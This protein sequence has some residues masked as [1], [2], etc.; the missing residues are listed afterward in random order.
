MPHSERKFFLLEQNPGWREAWSQ[1]LI[2]AEDGKELRLRAIPGTGRPLASPDGDFGGLSLPSGVAVDGDDRVYILEAKAGR[3]KRFDPC[4]QTFTSLPCIAGPGDQ[5]RQVC[6]P[7]SLAVSPRGDLYIA[8]TGNRR[9]QV[10]ALKGL[11]L[12]AIWGPIL[13]TGIGTSAMRIDPTAARASRALAPVQFAAVFPPLNAVAGPPP[14][15]A[16]EPADCAPGRVFPRCTWEPWDIA[17]DPGCWAFV[18]DRVN[19]L[20][21]RFDP[22]GRWHSA[23]AEESPGVRLSKPTSLALDRSGRLYVIQEGKDY[24]VVLDETGGFVER[25]QAPEEAEGRFDPQA[26]TVDSDGNLCVS[27]RYTRALYRYCLDAAGCMVYAGLCPVDGPVAA[28]A[29]DK[30]GNLLA[31]DPQ[32]GRVVCLP[33][34]AALETD[35]VFY[36]EALDSQIYRCAW[37]QVALQASVPPGSLIRVDTFTSESLKT[38]DEIRSLEQESRWATGQFYTQEIEGEWDCLVRSPRGRFLWLRLSLSGNGTVTPAIRQVQVHFPRVTSAEYL[39]AVYR[40]DPESADFLERFLSIFDSLNAK[41]AAQVAALPGLLDPLSAPVARSAPDR[42]DFLTWLGT[43]MG[44]SLE[45]HWPEA[46]RRLLLA[47]AHQL[48]ALRGT[49]DGLRLHLEI[50]T[51]ETPRI[52][53][54]FRL[55][56]WL[57]LGYGKL[58]DSANLWGDAVIRRLQLDVFSQVGSFLLKD[59]QDP[60]LDPINQSAYQFTVFLPRKTCRSQAEEQTLQRILELASPAHAQGTIQFIEP[61][62]RVGVQAFVGLDTVVGRLPKHTIEGEGTLGYDTVIGPALGEE[63]RPTLRIGKAARIG[64]TTRL[65]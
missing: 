19:G 57:Y 14:E 25:I 44:L 28:I 3:L 58:G 62:F 10:F 51:G 39:P 56:R 9:V 59:T 65:D 23:I 61:N 35:G 54:H 20:I 24:V 1:G 7:R 13:V 48:F 26:V 50:Y 22:L 11:A 53:E 8:D 32:G 45:R 55:R 49:L 40:E 37:H 47:K 38:P 17:L 30:A 43:W 52:I 6:N 4:T 12:R 2:L 42:L 46:K 34:R 21:H 31:A 18:S 27:E 5:P 15:S 41:I 33:A 60:L 64:S 36:T 63:Q 16:E 29:F